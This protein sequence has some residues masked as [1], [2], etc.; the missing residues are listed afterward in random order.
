MPLTDR[1]LARMESAGQAQLSLFDAPRKTRRVTVP[2]VAETSRDA[3]DKAEA[4]AG[5]QMAAVLDVIRAAGERGATADEVEAAMG[6]CSGA[7]SARINRLAELRKIWKNGDRRITR[8]GGTAYVW[9]A[10]IK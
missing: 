5:S 1:E 4:A 8:R 6:I 3:A 10:V 7:S 9:R 2:G